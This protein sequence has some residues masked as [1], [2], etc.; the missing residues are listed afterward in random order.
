MLAL[1]S[2][3]RRL[4]DTYENQRWGPVRI[5]ASSETLVVEHALR[6]FLSSTEVPYW[7]YHLAREYAERYDANFGT[8][9]IP[10]SAP[11]VEEIAEFLRNYHL[12]PRKT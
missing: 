10:E 4:Q 7:A 11:M 3:I 1:L 9:L 6:C 8:G 2:E 12:N 5:V